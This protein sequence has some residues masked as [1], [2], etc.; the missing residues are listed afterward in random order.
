[1]KSYAEA[2]SRTKA[3]LLVVEKDWPPDALTA[4]A[5]DMQGR[6]GRSVS[7][8]QGKSRLQGPKRVCNNPTPAA[9]STRRPFR[10]DPGPGN[11]I[12]PTAIISV[13]EM[14]ESLPGL[15]DLLPA[16]V[17][18]ARGGRP[19]RYRLARTQGRRL[20]AG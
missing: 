9:G 1:M 10:L 2:T 3:F 12:K 13:A 7:R 17:R 11:L 15:S 8:P 5:V 4:C 18:I 16:T 19:G 14:S 20:I 6:R